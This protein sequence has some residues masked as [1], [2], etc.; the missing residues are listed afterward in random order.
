MA[1]RLWSMEMSNASITTS[2]LRSPAARG[3]YSA[4]RRSPPARCRRRSPEHAR[5]STGS[6][7]RGRRAPPAPRAAARFRSERLPSRNKPTANITGS[8][9]QE[10][11]LA[12]A[13]PE[14]GGTGDRPCR[15]AQEDVIAGLRLNRRARSHRQFT[16]SL[17]CYTSHPW[18]KNSPSPRNVR[19]G[20]TRRRRVRVRR[21]ADDR[22]RAHAHLLGD[23]VLP[24]RVPRD[25]H[26]PVRAERERRVRVPRAAPVCDAARRRPCSRRTRSPLRPRPSSLSPSSCACASA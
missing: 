3:S 9:H 19:R 21:P 13:E 10:H 23:H 26:R 8:T 15:E 16:P 4:S 12:P 17:W 5:Q 11:A 22:A 2:T 14:M 6:R 25:F 20:S 18:S 7:Y 1:V 24:L